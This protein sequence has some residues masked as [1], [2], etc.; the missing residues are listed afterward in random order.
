MDPQELLTSQMLVTQ[1][2]QGDDGAV[3]ALYQ[4]Y[5]KR[6]ESWAHGRLPRK[7]RGPLDTHVFA[8]DV[9]VTVLLRL[10]ELRNELERSFKSYVRNAVFNQLAKTTRAAAKA[11]ETD[12]VTEIDVPRDGNALEDLLQQEFGEAL[13]RAVDRLD[14]RHRALLTLRFVEDLPYAEVAQQADLPSPDAARMAVSRACDRL[15]ED[16]QTLA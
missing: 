9:L 7:A 2:Q 5:I 16:L 13:Q 15:R 12:D 8:H 4:R 10:P 1:A 3:D 11:P 6:V 14:E